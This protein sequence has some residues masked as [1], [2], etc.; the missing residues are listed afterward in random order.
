MH[1]ASLAQSNKFGG[2]NHIDLTPPQNAA[3][4][5]ESPQ[6]LADSPSQLADTVSADELDTVRNTFVYT[7]PVVEKEP[8]TVY[9]LNIFYYIQLVYSILYTF[10]SHF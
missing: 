5:A 4:G 10:Y 2:L 8:R 7:A 6:V 1:F 3:A 9:V